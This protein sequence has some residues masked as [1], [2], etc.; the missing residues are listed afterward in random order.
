MIFINK[1][2]NKMKRRTRLPTVPKKVLFLKLQ[3]LNIATKEIVIQKLRKEVQKTFT[4]TQIKYRFLQAP[5]KKTVN[6]D[7][8]FEF[9]TYMCIHQFK[10]SSGA[11]YIVRTIRSFQS[12]HSRTPSVLVEQKIGRSDLELYSR[13]LDGYRSSS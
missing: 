2:M 11:S 9:A 6:K 13:S 5:H 12:S 3:F 10:R 1:H 4:A 7:K 8:L